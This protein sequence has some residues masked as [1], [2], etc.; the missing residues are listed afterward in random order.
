MIAWSILQS[1]GID[2]EGACFFFPFYLFFFHFILCLFSFSTSQ[3]SSSI[4]HTPLRCYR[5]LLL[6]LTYLR[7]P[8][9]LIL[10]FFLF[11]F[12]PP[13]R[14]EREK[15]MFSAFGFY[16]LPAASYFLLLPFFRIFSFFCIDGSLVE[17][18]SLRTL[19]SV[20][21]DAFGRLEANNF[22]LGFWCWIYQAIDK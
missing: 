3:I 20:T 18:V 15:K 17:C 13:H 22:A 9:I 19:N 1:D 21:S 5:H 7:F 12:N 14:R 6:L 8:F 11:L 10:F 16:C 4:T 2:D